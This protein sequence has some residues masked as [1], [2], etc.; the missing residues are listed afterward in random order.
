MTRGAP[1]ASFVAH[2][3]IECGALGCCTSRAPATHTRSHSCAPPVASGAVIRWLTTVL[4][5][6]QL[7]RPTHSPGGTAVTVPGMAIHVPVD[8]VHSATD[9]PRIQGVSMKAY[10]TR[11][12]GFR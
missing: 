2:T 3:A 5:T 1:S 9:S 8:R 11:T 12:Q 4:V 10:T 6:R 7:S